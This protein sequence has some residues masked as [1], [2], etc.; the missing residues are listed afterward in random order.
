SKLRREY[1]KGKLTA[2]TVQYIDS[3]TA[4]NSFP[5]LGNVTQDTE[6]SELPVPQPGNRGQTNHLNDRLL[7]NIGMQADG[8]HERGK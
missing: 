2:D 1:Y 8:I 4:S 7:W 3:L 6:V 5:L